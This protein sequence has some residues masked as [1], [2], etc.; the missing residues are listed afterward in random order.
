MEI[1]ARLR[2]EARAT[3]ERRLLV[4]TGSPAATRAAAGDALAAAEVDPD[5]AA[6]VGPGDAYECDRY[7]DTAVDEL[8]GTTREAIIFDCHERCEP[9]ALGKLVGAVDGGGLFVLL[10]PPLSEW[11]DRTDDFDRSLAV[12][13]F[14][15]SDVGTA[16]RERLVE[17]IKAHRG[18]AV[19]SVGD[20]RT[21]RQDGLTTPAPRRGRASP[22]PPTEH[23][24]PVEAYQR[25][26]TQDQ[27][28]AVAALENLQQD[29]NAVVLE[30][31]RGRGKSSAA[32]L[33]AGSLAAAGADV[34]VTAP[35]SESTTA[36]FE[37]VAELLDDA[38]VRHERVSGS[39]PCVETERGRVRYCPPATA[40]EL[41]EDP[42]HVIVDEAAALPVGLLSATLEADAVAFSTTIHGYEGAG[43]GFSVRFRDH[44]A[45]SDFAV[46][47]QRLAEPIRYAPGDPVEVWSFRVL[48]LD[49]RP[50]V[51]QLVADASPETV[52]YREL[53]T[54]ELRADEHL[55]REVFG[56]LVLAHY[57]TEP[58][59][60]ARLLDAPNV[61]VQALCHDGH[62]VS[63]ALLAREGHLPAELRAEVYEGARIRGNLLP[64]VLTGQL[65]DESAG[66]PVGWRVLRIATHAS[67]RSRGL[68]SLLLDRVRERAYE[69][70]FDW[71]GVAYGAT[72]D[73]V[74]F[75]DDNG[76]D[77]VHISTTRNER[78]GEHSVIMLDP[79]SAAGEALHERHTAWFHR[80][81]RGSIRE[82]L[83]EVDPETVVAAC[84]A[85]DGAPSLEL[86]AWEWRHVAGIPVGN[87]IFETAPDPV[88]RLC[89]RHV[90]AP[91]KEVL[92]PEQ[93]RLLV[94]KFL[95][96]QTWEQIREAEGFHGRRACTRATGTALEPLVELYGTET[97]LAELDRLR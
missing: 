67:A 2:A 37:R 62:V 71:L 81:I 17:T 26:R 29:S 83:S 18:I 6:A 82:T 89:Y 40:A 56:L 87:A 55:L 75:W 46:T 28:A 39:E 64:D 61:T 93:Q 70:D 34:L 23:N 76:F 32:G 52:T 68:G 94:R 36:V 95:Q 4:L 19:V 1:A 88:R 84:R 31:D 3:G 97:A 7:E 48:A 65:R 92:T 44:L 45:E 9:N 11:P 12:P 74:S 25:C 66:E 80:R 5:R 96:G 79:L 16:F 54:A 38:R 13:P 15:E 27:V 20:E 60:L 43:R 72:P 51:E 14:D 57:R 22:E 58:N 78:S 73:L 10:A 35:T 30:A 77:T 59:D 63:V 86:T 85:S 47:E 91:Q 24:F 53:S 49:A 42:D 90:A 50:P 69:R 41:P 33:A 8:L 21:V